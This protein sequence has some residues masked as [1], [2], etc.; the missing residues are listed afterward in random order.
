MLKTIISGGYDDHLK[1]LVNQLK[2]RSTA[3]FLTFNPFPELP[4][5]AAPWQMQHPK[6][7]LASLKHMAKILRE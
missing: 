6:L 1:Y 5:K 7:Y 4:E 3:I 2:I